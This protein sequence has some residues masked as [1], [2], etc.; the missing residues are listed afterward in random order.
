MKKNNETQKLGCLTGLFKRHH[1]TS[2]II[3]VGGSSTRYGGDM[4][5]QLLSLDSL[6]VAAHSL[7]AFERC[8]LID[9]IVVVC[10]QGDEDHYRQMAKEL[11]VTKLSQVV[12][13]GSTRQ[14][15]ALNGVTATAEAS[16]YVLIHDGARPLVT[17]KIIR[18]VTLAAHANRA[19]C[20]A[21]PSKDTVKIADE[22]GNIL[23]TEDRNYVY[24]AATPQGFYKTL[25]EACAHAA[26]KEG[27][28]V[29][30]DASLLEHFYYKVKLVDC[31]SENIK[32]TTPSDLVLAEALLQKRKQRSQD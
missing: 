28:D 5:K 1:F 32:I 17:D 26:K 14:E 11:S 4:P 24:L 6:P 19:A 12:I 21:T 23:R 20:A 9:E 29:T 25:Y 8:D 3:L 7:L 30:D 22:K 27:F 18:D 15:S 13:G 16:K 2:A 31:G 10:R